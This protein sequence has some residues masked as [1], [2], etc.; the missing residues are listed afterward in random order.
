[1]IWHTA[2]LTPFQPSCTLRRVVVSTT[3]LGCRCLG[4]EAGGQQ[5]LLPYLFNPSR[6]RGCMAE[7]NYRDGEPNAVR[8]DQ[9]VGQQNE[10]EHRISYSSCNYDHLSHLFFSR[11]LPVICLGLFR[12]SRF[13]FHDHQVFPRAALAALVSLAARGGAYPLRRTFQREQSNYAPREA[14]SRPIH[15]RASLDH[16]LT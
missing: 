15:R 11:Q 12:L 2:M 7:D 16:H 10:A 13:P 1:M 5:P 4:Q 9:C 14:E 3:S 6:S 8:I